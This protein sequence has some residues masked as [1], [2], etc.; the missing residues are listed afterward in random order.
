MADVAT[1]RTENDGC[2]VRLVCGR[3]EDFEFLGA[4]LILVTADRCL[5]SGPK[6][7]AMTGRWLGNRGCGLREEI[8]SE[9]NQSG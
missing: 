4:V 3:E 8:W 2:A 9:S 1:P 5:V 7:D 6:R